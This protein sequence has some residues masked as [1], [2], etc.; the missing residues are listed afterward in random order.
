[1]FINIFQTLIRS[2]SVGGAREERATGLGHTY[3]RVDAI[4]QM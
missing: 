3:V 1:M 4:Y 2:K